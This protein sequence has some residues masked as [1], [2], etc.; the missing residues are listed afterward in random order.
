[1]VTLVWLLDPPPPLLRRSLL[2]RVSLPLIPAR[3]CL[4][5]PDGRGTAIIQ[6]ITEHTER[7]FPLP[8]PSLLCSHTDD[9][10]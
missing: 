6:E 4:P 10:R 3:V 7:V 9:A 8:R 5:L 2:S 1:M